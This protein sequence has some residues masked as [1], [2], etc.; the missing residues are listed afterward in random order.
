MHNQYDSRDINSVAQFWWWKLRLQST[1]ST[2]RVGNKS[3]NVNGWWLATGTG[4]IQPFSI[5]TQHYSSRI[6]IL[7]LPSKPRNSIKSKCA[8]KQTNKQ[9]QKKTR[10]KKKGS[11]ARVDEVMSARR[12]WKDKRVKEVTP[13]SVSFFQCHQPPSVKQAR[14]RRQSLLWS[15]DPFFNHEM[16]CTAYRD[17]DKWDTVWLVVTLLLSVSSWI[18][19]SHLPPRVP[20]A[21]HRTNSPGTYAGRGTVGPFFSQTGLTAML[22]TSTA[23]ECHKEN[24]SSTPQSIFVVERFPCPTIPSQPIWGTSFSQR[25][26]EFARFSC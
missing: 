12:C 23:H 13:W 4:A 14:V 18:L 25:L 5:L 10:G 16:G 7:W 19:T 15:N 20:S 8:F 21:M 2:K 26:Q 22:M 24:C 11:V 6:Y 3:D 17:F 1:K 9:N